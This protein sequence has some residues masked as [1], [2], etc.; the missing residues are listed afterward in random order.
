MNDNKAYMFINYKKK[1][2]EKKI[3]LLI[4]TQLIVNKAIKIFW[5][6]NQF[7]TYINSVQKYLFIRFGTIL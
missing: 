3:F 5:I 1:N 7:Y 4:K 6:K 2:N